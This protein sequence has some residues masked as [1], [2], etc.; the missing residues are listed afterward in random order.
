MS[1]IGERLKD[2][3]LRLGLNQTIF[4]GAGGVKKGA[5][6][7]YESDR[8]NPDAAYWTAVA[9]FLG[10]DVQYVLTGVRSAN[11]DEIAEESDEALAARLDRV[12]GKVMRIAEGCTRRPDPLKLASVRDLALSA[13][14]SD[15][16]IKAI[17]SLLEQ[18]SKP[19]FWLD[20]AGTVEGGITQNIGLAG[21]IAGHTINNRDKEKKNE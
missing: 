19:D 11:L 12:T 6:I 18:A 20:S 5:Q 10:V 15:D 3:R 17:F 1:T 9:T 14:L 21:Q 13:H 8:R 2:E 7:Q 4:A 16:Q